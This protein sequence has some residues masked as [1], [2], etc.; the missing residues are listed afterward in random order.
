MLYVTKNDTAFPLDNG[1]ATNG[2]VHFDWE[3]ESCTATLNGQPYELGA[4]IIAEGDYLIELTDRAGNVARYSFTI[5]KTPPKAK[6]H[7]ASNELIEDESIT[8]YSIYFDWTEAGCTATLNGE[9]YSKGNL[10]NDTGIYAFALSDAVGNVVYLTIEVYKV[11]P[12][13]EI[14]PINNFVLPYLNDGFTIT[15]S[16]EGCTATLNGQSY[17][18]ETEITAEGEYKFILINKVGLEYVEDI[19]IDRTAPSITIYDAD[20]NVVTNDVCLSFVCFDWTEA[21]CTATVNGEPYKAKTYMTKDGIYTLLL[22][23]AAG[24]VGSRSIRVARTKPSVAL[25]KG[26]GK[27]LTNGGSTAESVVVVLTSDTYATIQVDEVDYVLGDAITDIG[28][29]TVIVTD[30]YGNVAEYSFTIKEATSQ[31]DSSNPLGKLTEGSPVGSYI[32]IALL[33]V[34]VIIYIVV[35]LIRAKR[36]G[37]FRRK[38]N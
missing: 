22:T 33:A 7:T 29:H 32:L 23:D 36:K 1:A 8:R 31:R 26:D 13:A 28:T 18:K 11:I 15:W 9:P 19:I 38:L 35:P 21:G 4:L 2:N 12:N 30:I 17:E 34:I 6:A 3:E 14:T 37:A 20:G 27:E 10:I 5:D 16:E 24:N 25:I